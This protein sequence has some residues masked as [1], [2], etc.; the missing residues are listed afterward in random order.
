M[1]LNISQL[2]RGF[3]IKNLML[4]DGEKFIQSL[5]FQE[6]VVRGIQFEPNEGESQILNLIC[7][8]NDGDFFT[9]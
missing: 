5:Y 4:F 6:E 2:D 8:T 3:Q 7:F 1:Y 9:L